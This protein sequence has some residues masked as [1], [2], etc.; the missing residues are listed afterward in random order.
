ML[1]ATCGGL[2]YIFRC[3]LLISPCLWVLAPSCNVVCLVIDLMPLLRLN[4]EPWSEAEALSDYGA[5]TT[6]S[7][8]F[9]LKYN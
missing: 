3:H 2:F 4:M 7:F 6:P 1:W 8:V 9:L 5:S